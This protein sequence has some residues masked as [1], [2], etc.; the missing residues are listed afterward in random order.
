MLNYQKIKNLILHIVVSC[1]NEKDGITLFK[2]AKI[3][4][5][6]DFGYFAQNNQS[7]S[8]I[9]YLKFQYG[10]VPR[11]L[12][13]YIKL[14]ES[15]NLLERKTYITDDTEKEVLI[16]QTGKYLNKTRFSN[17][18]IETINNTIKGAKGLSSRQLSTETHYHQSWITT[19]TGE[20]I[21]Y[22]KAKYCVFEWLNYYRDMNKNDYYEIK[23]IQKIFKD[24]EVTNLLSTIQTL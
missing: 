3:L 8:G 16:T 12:R 23:K 5:F 14:L 1:Q 15:E 20:I 11:G 17:N 13:D 18:E 10:P 22:E 19:F 7:I 6:I 9:D 21:D 2:L 4:Y 24:K